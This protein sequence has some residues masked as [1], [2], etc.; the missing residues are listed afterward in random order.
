MLSPD[1]PALVEQAKPPERHEIRAR[2]RRRRWALVVAACVVVAAIAAYAVPGVRWRLQLLAIGAVGGIPEL[3]FRELASMLLPSSGQEKM[4][5]LIETRNPHAVVRVPPLSDAALERGAAAYRSQCAECHGP[6]GT[7]ARGPALVGRALKNGESDWALYRTIRLG[8]PRTLMAPHPLEGAPL[9]EIVGHVRQLQSRIAQT[10]AAAP[11]S[12]L[13]KIGLDAATLEATRSPEDEWRTYAGA[14]NGQRHSTLEQLTPDNIDRLAVRWVHQFAGEPAPIEC[15]PIVHAGR[16]FVTVPP[17]VFAIDAR[18]GKTLWERDL[19]VHSSRPNE[20]HGEALNRG[21][22]LL[23]DRLFVGTRDARLFAL[24]ASTGEVLWETAVDD[25]Q[26]F[27]ISGAPLAVRD[28]VVVGVGMFGGGR[29]FIAAYDAATGKQRWRFQTIPEPGA[30]GADTW[31]GDSWRDGGGPTWITGSYDP[32][33]DLL[34]WGVGN[35]KPDYDAAA[36]RGDNLF[37]D[38]AVALRGATGELVWHFQFTPADDRDWDSN[39]TPVLVDYA[40]NGAV[41]RRVLWANRNGF[42]YVL[43]RDRGRFVTGAPF[44]YQNWAEKLDATGRPIPSQEMRAAKSG[45]LVH[46]SGTG[47]TNWWS[48]SY[49]PEL[50]LFF[51]PVLEQGAVFVPGSKNAPPDTVRPFYTGVRALQGRTGR[52]LWEHRH[53]PRL[54]DNSTGGLLSTRSGLVFGSDLSTF[55][56]LDARSGKRLYAFETGAAIAAAPITYRIDG[57]QFVSIISGRDLLTFSL[58]AGS[59]AASR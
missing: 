27:H 28:M 30:K 47:A 13:P 46:P 16:M 37:T 58:P 11:G 10:T 59:Q 8:V 39:Q 40:A 21:P 42:Y 18:T 44:V 1:A 14:Y 45:Y 50:D 43:D 41:D 4:I 51:V 22:A 36:R 5:R 7:G 12:D 35:P 53:E 2:V 54:T 56:T 15:A 52:M 20:E 38:S 48:P 19:H 9:W 26:R 17:R 49:D 29:G 57:Q 6:D 3:E 34:V 23:G 32:Q 24:S 55:F 33:Q 25:R 31:A